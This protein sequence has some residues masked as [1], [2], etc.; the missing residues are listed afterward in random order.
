[1]SFGFAIFTTSPG[2]EEQ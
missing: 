2:A 1:V